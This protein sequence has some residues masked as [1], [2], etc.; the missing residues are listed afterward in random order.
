MEENG[1]MTSE[2]SPINSHAV[3]EHLEERLAAGRTAGEA[4]AEILFVRDKQV[5]EGLMSR[6]SRNDYQEIV[7]GWIVQQDGGESL[8]HHKMIA[9]VYSQRLSERVNWELPNDVGAQIEQLWQEWRREP[10]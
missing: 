8:A 1:A 5:S 7:D 10:K 6:D 2:D 4:A 3:S 9:Q